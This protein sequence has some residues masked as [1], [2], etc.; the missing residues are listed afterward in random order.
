MIFTLVS[1]TYVIILMTMITGENPIGPENL[2][3]FSSGLSVVLYVFPIIFSAIERKDGDV[4]T[5][6]FSGN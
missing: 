3:G 4:T 6:T 1:F 2:S 5:L